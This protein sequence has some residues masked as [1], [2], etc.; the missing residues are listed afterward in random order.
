MISIPDHLRMLPPGLN[1]RKEVVSILTRID[2]ELVGE[3]RVVY[4]VNGSSE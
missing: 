3:S 1:P 4:V 2:E